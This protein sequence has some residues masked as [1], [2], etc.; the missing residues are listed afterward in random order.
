[1]ALYSPTRIRRGEQWLPR[2]GEDLSSHPPVRGSSTF[3]QRAH[4]H[5]TNKPT[6]RMASITNL[7]RKLVIKPWITKTPFITSEQTQ[8]WS[9]WSERWR[10]ELFTLTGQLPVSGKT[11]RWSRRIEQTGRVTIPLA[12][13]VHSCQGPTT[14]PL[15]PRY[16]RTLLAPLLVPHF[17]PPPWSSYAFCSHLHARMCTLICLPG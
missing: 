16:L 3:S 5:V 12:N 7:I 11:G 1:M 17:A 9:E 6:R 10:P 2:T 14:L 15:P 8:N 13:I 4:C